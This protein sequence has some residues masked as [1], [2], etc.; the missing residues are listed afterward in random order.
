MYIMPGYVEYYEEGGALYIMSNLLQNKVKITEKPLQEEFYAIV[1]CGGCPDIS[2]P[3]TR[4]LHEQELLLN[5]EEITQTLK[6][7]VSILNDTLLLTIMP[8]EGCNFRCPYC[9][10]DHTPISMTRAVL[11]RIQEYI[12]E[13]APRFKFLQINWFGGEPTLC[14]DVVLETAYMA[15]DLAQKHGFL[16]NS[17]I[18]TNGYLLDLNTFQQLC[19]AGIMHYQI[20]LDGWNHDQTRPHVSGR[21]TLQTILENLTAI[22]ALPEEYQFQIILRHNILAGDRDLSWYDHLYK[23]FGADNRFHVIV[24]AVGNWGGESVKSLDLLEDGQRSQILLEHV[25]YL[26]KIGFQKGDKRDGPFSKICYASYPRGFV[27]RPSGKIEKCT[28]ALDH[29]KNMVGYVDPDKGV[30]INDEANRLWS[31]FDLK[32]ECHTCP[33]VLKCLN[34]KCK[35]PAIIDEI[36]VGCSRTPAEM[37]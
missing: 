27:F 18:T 5:S 13:Q 31:T 10:E 16:Y 7:A 15:Q 3:L 6:E 37:Y 21:G 19:A 12:T 26:D 32:P 20:T 34:M 25:A 14:K 28:I 17:S 29:P 11:D 1:R 2:T 8:T 4:F 33:D 24:R 9:Y 35:K 30:V 36:E 23:F 22:S